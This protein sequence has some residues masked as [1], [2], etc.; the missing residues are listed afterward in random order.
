MST[1]NKFLA[2]AIDLSAAYG[3]TDEQFWSDT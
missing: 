2:L 1:I 3:E